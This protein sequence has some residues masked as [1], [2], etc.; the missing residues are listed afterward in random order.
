M[1]S[2]AGGAQLTSIPSEKAFRLNC[3][4]LSQASVEIDAMFPG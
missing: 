2:K 4:E 1:S 3:V